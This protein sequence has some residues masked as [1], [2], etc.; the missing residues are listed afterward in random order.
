MRRVLVVKLLIAIVL[1][2]LAWET[3]ALAATQAAIITF[4][5]SPAD[6]Q[7]I[8]RSQRQPVKFLTGL[9]AG[10]RLKVLMPGRG[11]VYR[12]PDGR[13]ERLR[14]EHGEVQIES[15]RSAVTIFGNIFAMIGDKLTRHRGRDGSVSARGP[16]H[17]QGALKLSHPDLAKGRAQV[18]AGRRPFAVAWTGGTRP[19]RVTVSDRQGGVVVD[20]DNI[21][22][23]QLIV[24]GAGV[25]LGAQRYTVMVRG[26]TGAPVAGSFLGVPA[27]TPRPLSAKGD[28][29]DAAAA[30]L[31]A[32]ELLASGRHR[33]FEAYNT[34]AP[35]YDSDRTA[36][37]FM[38]A[39]AD[40]E[41]P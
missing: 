1:G 6:Y 15:E 40:K 19:F 9:R 24:G 25:R 13:L 23:W 29:L 2:F 35:F 22:T 39:M 30:V 4:D 12:Q 8:R 11:L 17:Q 37:E 36:R 7:L 21:Q 16:R 10:D 26:A 32:A 38:H 3:P 5:G 33:T 28:D 14:F 18:E 41:L 34:L 20:E 27:A 31:H